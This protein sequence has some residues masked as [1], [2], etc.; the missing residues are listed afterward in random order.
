[1]D[2]LKSVRIVSVSIIEAAYEL[3]NFGRVC[4]VHMAS[5]SCFHLAVCSCLIFSSISV[6]STLI[7]SRTSGVG[8][9]LCCWTRVLSFCLMF[10][11]KHGLKCLI[12][13][14]EICVLFV[15]F[16]LKCCNARSV[17]L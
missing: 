6:F 1:M 13:P 14:V 12:V 16:L 15:S 8:I 4:V 3:P 2:G 7:L 5:S 17:L 10:L 9:C 11:L